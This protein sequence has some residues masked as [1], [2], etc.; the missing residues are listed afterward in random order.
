M[1]F[2]FQAKVEKSSGESETLFNEAGKR[3][4]IMI[5]CSDSSV[6]NSKLLVKLHKPQSKFNQLFS[7]SSGSETSQMQ[8]PYRSLIEDQPCVNNRSTSS[9]RA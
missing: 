4:S 5:K 1:G 7:F 2:N 9:I 3:T 6:A 8:F